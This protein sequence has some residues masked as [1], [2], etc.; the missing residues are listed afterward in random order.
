MKL[1]AA[2]DGY[3]LN[4]FKRGLVMEFTDAQIQIINAFNLACSGEDV[5]VFPVKDKETG[6]THPCLAVQVDGETI[7]PIGLLFTP[8][9]DDLS[10]YEFPEGLEEVDSVDGVNFV[11]SDDDEEEDEA[12][13]PSFFSR[14]KNRLFNR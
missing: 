8:H 3:S 12:S 14:L 10:K 11:Y 5:I 2:N 9:Q 7:I 13:Q 6:K 1:M 4:I